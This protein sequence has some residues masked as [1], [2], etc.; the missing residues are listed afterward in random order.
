VHAPDTQTWL[1]AQALPHWP[2]LS[3]S[4]ASCVMLMQVVPQFS[5]PGPQGPIWQAPLMQCWKN[6]WHVMPHAPQS[7]ALLRTSTQTPLQLVSPGRQPHTPALHACAAAHA[8]PHAPQLFGSLIR[9]EQSLPVQ[10]VPAHEHWP[11]LHT[12]P[13]RQAFV[14]PPQ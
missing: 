8:R 11:L 4:L 13:A 14:Q 1:V 9:S 7:F 6:G 2:Q 3:G 12:S 10:V 5:C